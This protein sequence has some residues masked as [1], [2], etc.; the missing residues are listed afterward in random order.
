MDARRIALGKIAGVYGVRGWVKLHSLTRPA[1]N[2]LKYRHWWIAKGEGFEAQLLDGKAHA[3][4]LIAQISGPD[5]QPI[6]DRDFAASLIGSEVQVER[7]AFPKLPK[8]QYYWVDLIG[9]QVVNEQ[10]VAL[11]EVTDMTS[12]GAQDVLVLKQGEVERLIPFVN[13]P[14]VKSVDLKSRRIVCDWQPDY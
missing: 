7:S 12:N 11:G 4:A 9:L 8:G 14:I 6:E 2:L 13:G 3:G 10:D 1:T 5:G